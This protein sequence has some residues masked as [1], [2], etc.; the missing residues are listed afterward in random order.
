MD[1]SED[2]CGTAQLLIFVRSVDNEFNVA[3]ELAELQSLQE[4][5]RGIDIFEKLCATIQT[6]NL[7]YLDSR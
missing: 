1:E 2:I 4:R 6:L 3:E 5:T 7:K